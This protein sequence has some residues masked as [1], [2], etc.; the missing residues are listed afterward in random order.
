MKEYV[1]KAYGKSENGNGNGVEMFVKN[2]DVLI[3]KDNEAD[4]FNT[5][6]DAQQEIRKIRSNFSKDW[7]LKPI[8]KG[9]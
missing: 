3:Y 4:T 6:K 8:V 1:V 2:S 5:K 7:D 9:F